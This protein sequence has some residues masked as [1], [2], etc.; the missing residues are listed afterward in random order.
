MNIYYNNEVFAVGVLWASRFANLNNKW[1]KLAAFMKVG[2]RKVNKNGNV[3]PKLLRY[4]LYMLPLIIPFTKITTL[5]II[6]FFKL[7]SW[8]RRRNKRW[9]FINRTKLIYNTKMSCSCY[10]MHYRFFF[11]F[12]TSVFIFPFGKLYAHLKESL[13]LIAKLLELLKL[14]S[15]F[16][17][18]LRI[19]L[20]VIFLVLP[21]PKNWATKFFLVAQ[22]L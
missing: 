8:W 1:K 19:L 5:K 6:L 9:C 3:Y 13:S 17:C 4:I 10:L 15:T 11:I 2:S 14:T 20:F 21:V 22:Y 16:T 7:Y 12:Y 18:S